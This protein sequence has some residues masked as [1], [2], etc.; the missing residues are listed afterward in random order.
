MAPQSGKT[1]SSSGNDAGLRQ[2]IV[3]HT[4]F[5]YK[6]CCAAGGA[7]EE[8]EVYET[9]HYSA[10][11]AYANEAAADASGNVYSP[12]LEW[13]HETES[14]LTP[15]ASLTA[16]SDDAAPTLGSH[17]H[18]SPS[19]RLLVQRSS[20]LPKKHSI[21]VIDGY[22]EVQLGRDAAHSS[23]DVPR[24]RLKEMEV[25][26]I[27]ATIYWDQD[28]REWAV[29]D[30][31]SKHGTFFQAG[32]SSGA[33]GDSVVVLPSPQAAAP[34]ADDP[35][36]WRLSSPRMASIPRRLNH[37]DRL[38][39]GS[40]TFIVHIHD[41]QIPCVE[42]S[43][44]GDDEIPLCDARS[45]QREASRKRKRD[46]TLSSETAP[47]KQDPKRALATLKRSLLTRH[48][49]YQV[50][51]TSTHN[52]ADVFEPVFDARDRIPRGN[53]NGISLSDTFLHI[54]SAA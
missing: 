45:S 50:V 9:D 24:I 49:P 13:P 35:R 44:T 33:F 32:L 18:S 31:G 23:S 1:V 46:L 43:P 11:V 15:P 52:A 37:L 40:T 20:V 12:A 4:V 39:L 34:L 47:T 19:L 27:H 38:S 41:D 29:V 53:A 6:E 22:E 42:C 36:G 7:M 3:V 16:H 5:T 48:A 54:Y 25:S 2:V 21:A 8:G 10:T 28:R 26:K 51:Q 30:M 14:E 17:S